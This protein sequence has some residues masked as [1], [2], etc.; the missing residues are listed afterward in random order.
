LC[1]LTSMLLKVLPSCFSTER[2]MRLSAV[3]R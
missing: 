3:H 1:E 2:D